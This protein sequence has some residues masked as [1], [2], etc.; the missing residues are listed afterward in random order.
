MIGIASQQRVQCLD[1]LGVVAL[2][3]G[4][5]GEIIVGRDLPWLQTDALP[6]MVR[7]LSQAP[8]DVIHRSQRILQ[9]RIVRL[10]LDES[11]E[12]ALRSL[13][14]PFSNLRGG[15]RVLVDRFVGPHARGTDQRGLRV[16]EQVHLQADPAEP[17]EDLRVVRLELLGSQPVGEGS[18][19]LVLPFRGGG[20][21]PERRHRVRLETQRD[22]VGRQCP[23][24][25]AAEQVCPTEIEGKFVRRRAGLFDAL[26]KI[27]GFGDDSLFGKQQRELDRPLLRNTGKTRPVL[28]QCHRRLAVP[29]FQEVGGQNEQAVRGLLEGGEHGFG[30][31]ER[32][33]IVPALRLRTCQR[34]SRGRIRRIQLEDTPE[35]AG[36]QRRLLLQGVN[37]CE[38]QVRAGQ[39]GLQPD[40]FTEER[41]AFDQP[42]LLKPNGAQ[43]RIGDRPR[44]RVTQGKPRLLIGLF[45]PLLLNKRDGPL[46]RLAPRDAAQRALSGIT[47]V[48]VSRLRRPQKQEPGYQ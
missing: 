46:E 22:V 19:E 37:L 16:L 43:H 39:A 47:G 18:L 44:V 24:R 11:L 12:Q 23:S 30:E 2:I 45:Q 5:K 40:R 28:D 8:L 6:Q 33:L 29:C 1:G 41:G 25:I 7:G 34:Q 13:E 42:V 20:R 27:D 26:E 10:L 3:P 14:L 17:E 48:R 9:L 35:E 4:N 32:S 21:L 36:G 31:I 15:Q 38:A